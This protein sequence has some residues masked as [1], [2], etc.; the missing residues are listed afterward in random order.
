MSPARP[1]AQLLAL[2]GRRENQGADGQH[3]SEDVLHAEGGRRTAGRLRAP[4]HDAGGDATAQPG[5]RPG[6]AGHCA[7]RE[8]DV[9]SV[10]VFFVFVTMVKI[11]K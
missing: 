10:C 4:Q 7:Q 5:R 9:G 3:R 2:S 8:A 1:C 6:F 11:I